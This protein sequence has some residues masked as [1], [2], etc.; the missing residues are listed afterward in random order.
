MIGFWNWFVKITGWPVQLCCFRTKR[1]YEDRKVQG[2]HIRGPAIIVSN[3]TS[4]YDY[5]VYLF[6]FWT[7][8]LRFQ[9]AEVL[10]EK[11]MLGRLLRHLGGIRVDRDGFDFGFIDRS[12]AVLDRGGIVGVFPESRLPKPEEERPL[13]FKVSAAYLAL[14][15]GAKIIPVYTNGSYFNRKRAR[16]VIGKPLYAADLAVDGADEKENLRVVSERLR[17]RIIELGK[18]LDGQ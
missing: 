17:E 11:P 6:V 9:M 18:L 1:I 5:A 3:H 16:V 4:V 7:R 8:T 13:E 12:Q 10:F 14:A 15:S 2:R